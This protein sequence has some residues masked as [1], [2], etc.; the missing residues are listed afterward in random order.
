MF[1]ADSRLTAHSVM[2][3]KWMLHIVQ[4]NFHSVYKLHARK[5]SLTDEWE[6]ARNGWRVWEHWTWQYMYF[7]RYR[8]FFFQG[9]GFSFRFIFKY[10]FV[11][12]WRPVKIEAFFLMNVF[13]LVCFCILIINFG[14]IYFLFWV[15]FRMDRKIMLCFKWMCFKIKCHM[16]NCDNNC[17]CLVFPFV[18][19]NWL[20]ISFKMEK[21]GKKINKIKRNMCCN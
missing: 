19:S 9:F 4:H 1:R 20:V 5:G 3:V 7:I 15:S 10:Y 2:Y 21:K 8:R 14:M 6:G 16:C 13:F 17:C 18:W 11:L 12:S